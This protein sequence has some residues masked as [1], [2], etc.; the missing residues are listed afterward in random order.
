MARRATRCAKAIDSRH[1][2]YQND[3]SRFLFLFRNQEGTPV[4]AR[5]HSRREKTVTPKADARVCRVFMRAD[6]VP[7][8]CHGRASSS[9]SSW[10]V[11]LGLRNDDT[12]LSVVNQSLKSIR[13][14]SVNLIVFEETLRKNRK[15]GTISFSFVPFASRN[16]I[17][18]SGAGNDETVDRDFVCK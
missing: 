3:R 13:D 6:L 18:S 15:K 11:E 2:R 16:D 5:L 9:S 14:R 4:S 10:S 12:P 8:S 7:A 1:R 17:G